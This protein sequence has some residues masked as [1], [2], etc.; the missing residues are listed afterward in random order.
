[1]SRSLSR[2]PNLYS[3]IVD[4]ITHWYGLAVFSFAMGSVVSN[5]PQD[6]PYVQMATKLEATFQGMLAQIIEA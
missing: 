2:M 3:T 4:C 1:M 6:S 5:S